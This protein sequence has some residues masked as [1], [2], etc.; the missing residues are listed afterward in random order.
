MDRGRRDHL[1]CLRAGKV[2]KIPVHWRIRDSRRRH[3]H[4]TSTWTLSS[5]VPRTVRD[6]DEAVGLHISIRS[7]T[8]SS[9]LYSGGVGSQ[10]A[11]LGLNQKRADRCQ[12]IRKLAT[13]QIRAIPH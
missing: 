1:A 5:Y 2:K 3:R 6:R 9:S 7:H 4:L 12:P 11:D 13:T 10:Q 8:L